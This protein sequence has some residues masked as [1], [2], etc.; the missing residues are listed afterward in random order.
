ME[1]LVIENGSSEK[2]QTTIGFNSNVQLS[3]LIYRDAQ[4]GIPTLSENSNDNMF[5]LGCPIESRNISVRLK[6]N[7]EALS[8]FK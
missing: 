7:V 5:L 2:N 3:H 8:K 6:L 4:N 1:T